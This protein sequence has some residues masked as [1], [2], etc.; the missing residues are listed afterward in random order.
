VLALALASAAALQAGCLAVPIVAVAAMS[1][2][3]VD[4]YKPAKDADSP[5]KGTV[6]AVVPYGQTR[7][8]RRAAIDAL[9]AEASARGVTLRVAEARSRA[10][11]QTDD[12]RSLVKKNPPDALVLM[13]AKDAGY[14]RGLA[15][16]QDAGVPVFVVGRDVRVDDPGLYVARIATHAGPFAPALF[17][18]IE[19]LRA[20]RQVA[21]LIVPDVGTP[22]PREPGARDAG[23]RRAAAS[24]AGR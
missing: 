12:L 18:A 7:A 20:G 6:V 8:E 19:R 24:N 3:G 2:D 21:R 22:D 13:P 17:D 9:R 14:D 4:T 5:L 11:G 10:S 15:A 16:A 1:G 23:S